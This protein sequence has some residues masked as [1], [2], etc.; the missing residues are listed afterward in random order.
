LR[1]QQFP[2]EILGVRFVHGPFDPG[3]RR[4]KFRV[5]FQFREGLLLEGLLFMVRRDRVDR[6]IIRFRL[7]SG[8]RRGRRLGSWEEQIVVI[9]G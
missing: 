1:R 8:R 6:D 4:F 9:N 2:D 7:F 3:H 5:G